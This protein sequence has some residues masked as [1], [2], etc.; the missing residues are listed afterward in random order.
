MKAQIRRQTRAS[1]DPI[2]KIVTPASPAPTDAPA[3]GAVLTAS[4]WGTS[5]GSFIQ[6]IQVPQRMYLTRKFL[7]SSLI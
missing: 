1:S 3:S 6:L 7:V 2:P 4:C 5:D